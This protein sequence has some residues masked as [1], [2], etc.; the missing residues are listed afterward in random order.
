MAVT[1]G[2]AGVGNKVGEAVG[3]AEGALGG[4]VIE[5]LV[6]P[7]NGGLQGE[8]G[9]GASLVLQEGEGSTGSGDSLHEHGYPV[10]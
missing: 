5:A 3:A 10:N 4:V 2:Q 8:G 6:G 1:D 7:V 9:G